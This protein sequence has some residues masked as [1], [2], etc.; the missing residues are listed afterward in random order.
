MKDVLELL[1]PLFK[2]P[3]F[4]ITGSMVGGFGIVNM[5]D[6]LMLR[7]LKAPWALIPDWFRQLLELFRSLVHPLFDLL[8]GW[9]SIELPLVWKDYLAMGVIV[10]FMRLR[11]T[12]VIARAVKAGELTSYEQN[13]W[14]G[15]LLLTKESNTRQ[16]I[17]FYLGRLAYALFFWPMKLFG[18]IGRYTTRKGKKIGKNAVEKQVIETQYV[19]FFSSIVWALVILVALLLLK[20]GDIILA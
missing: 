10:M 17:C 2:Q 15:K 4:I 7:I 13:F 1:K 18:A 9:F 8:L 11:S 16:R 3:W 12:S 6:S 5:L 14:T 20:A 19:V